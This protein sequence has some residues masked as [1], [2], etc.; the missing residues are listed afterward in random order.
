M[1]DMAEN[2]CVSIW[3]AAPRTKHPQAI[4]GQVLSE[5]R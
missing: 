5:E 3:G 4:C 2:F 1:N